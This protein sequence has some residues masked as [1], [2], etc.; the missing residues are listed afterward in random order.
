MMFRSWRKEAL[1]I[2][3][4]GGGSWGLG[5]APSRRAGREIPECIMGLG[6]GTGYGEGSWSTTT[7]KNRQ[8]ACY[9][10]AHAV[11]M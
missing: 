11:N 10:A 1:L 3:I 9:T 5:F 4:Y 2:C 6:L 8:S 7:C